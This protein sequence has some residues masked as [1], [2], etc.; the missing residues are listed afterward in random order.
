MEARQVKV[1]EVIEVRQVQE[2][3]EVSQVQVEEVVSV[4]A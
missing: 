1:E 4:P 2:V 3:I